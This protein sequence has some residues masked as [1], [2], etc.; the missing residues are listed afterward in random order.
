MKRIGTT[1]AVRCC[2]HCG[3]K[4]LARTVVFERR[5]RSRVHLGSDCAKHRG[6]VADASNVVAYYPTKTPGSGFRKSHHE[7]VGCYDDHKE[8]VRRAVD[9]GREHPEAV[10]I[11]EGGRCADTANAAT[12]AD[13]REVAKARYRELLRKMDAHEKLTKKEWQDAFR[14]GQRFAHDPE[15][16]VNLNRA[17]AS[18]SSR[19]A[20]AR[21]ARQELDHYK[22]HR[23][24]I[25][26][27]ELRKIRT[28]PIGRIG[29]ERVY[30]VDGERVRHVAIDFV[31]GGT[32]GRYRFVPQGEVW[33]EKTMVPTDFAPTILHEMVENRLMQS[34]G[35]SYDAAHERA[36]EAELPMRQAVARGTVKPRTHRG[37]VRVAGEW[38][39]RWEKTSGL[40]G[41]D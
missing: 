26:A 35:L 39:G 2:D 1:T 7:K 3:K 20:L 14:L 21:Q 38:Y 6:V 19:A 11:V 5:D 8:A 36:S 17:D 32:A 23:P 18:R 15:F 22:P 40:R 12:S 30:A 10:V 13:R 33:V 24:S 37:A 41:V 25:S 16:K 27:A 34:R 4:N 9:F 31:A 29:N 28:K